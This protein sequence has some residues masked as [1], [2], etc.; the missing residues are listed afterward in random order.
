MSKN[1]FIKQN[2]LVFWK[3][4]HSEF[5][6]LSNDLELVVTPYS[7]VTVVN[8]TEVET[9]NMYALT[10]LANIGDIKWDLCLCNLLSWIIVFACLYKGIKWSGKVVYVTATL[11][12]VLLIV[13][14][15]Y[16]CTLEGARDGISAFFIPRTWS[17]KNSL[18]DP[19]VGLPKYLP[20]LKVKPL[21]AKIFENVCEN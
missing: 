6:I 4:K 11:P 17:G 5:S 3:K 18:A 9:I 21:V 2:Y 14:L 1:V 16:G 15:V 12:Y 13:L 20:T 19:Q 8:G 7:K 10:E